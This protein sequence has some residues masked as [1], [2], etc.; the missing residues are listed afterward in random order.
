MKLEALLLNATIKGLKGLFDVQ[1]PE[2]QINFQKTRKDFKGD[3]TLLT[4]PFA[5]LSRKSPE[6]T[7]EI[8]GAYFVKNIDE[9]ASFNVIKGFLNLEISDS[10]WLNF[11]KSIFERENYGIATPKSGKTIMIEYSQPNT[12][13]PL[14]LGH[15]RNNMLGYSLANIL[16]ANGHKVIMANIINDRGIHICKSMLAWQKWGNGETP[17]SS[18]IKGDKLV[19]R[20]YVEFDKNYKKEIRELMEGGMDEEEASKKAPLIIEAQEMLQKWEAGDYEIKDLW[21]TMNSWVLKGFDQTYDYLG[22][23]FDE[24]YYESDT[25]LLGKAHVNNGLK[26]GIF[27][28]K[29]DGSIW[30]DLSE[31]NLDPKLLLRSDGTSVYITQDIGTAIQRFEDYSLDRQIYVVGDEQIH[32]FKVLFAILK[33]LGYSWADSNY[34][35]SYGM[36]ELPSGKM[37]SREGTIV[38]ADDI[39]EEMVQSARRVSEELGKLDDKD[40][41]E[42]DLLYKQIGLGALKY[43]LTRVDPKKTMLFNP[44]ESIDFNGNTGP[45]IQ[46]TFTR[47]N[48]L[49]K[50][51]NGSSTDLSDAYLP[52]AK[53]K[54][55]IKLIC[56]FPEIIVEAGESLSPAIIANYCYELAKEFNN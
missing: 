9:V 52:N 33:K 44:E 49:L 43:F 26:D 12:N 6:E 13:K 5:S 19:G 37:K 55:L 45:F 47:I 42:K 4:F 36:V 22:V 15:L 48:S 35:L 34:H 3:I 1:V 2:K 32:H 53:E 41:A 54:N 11:L 14:H 25:Y 29:E 31:Y 50:K 8:L 51:A 28:K 46:Y 38:D 10:Y 16:K 30:C 7:G 40:V 39:M 24:L 20:Y 17:E 27:Y 18:D 21:K 23:S 56:Q